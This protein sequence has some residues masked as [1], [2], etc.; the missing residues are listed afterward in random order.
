MWRSILGTVDFSVFV[1]GGTGRFKT[2]LA[3]LLQQHF[4]SGFAAHLLPGTWASTANFNCAQSR[5]VDVAGRYLDQEYACDQALPPTVALPQ[6]TGSG[7]A[8]DGRVAARC[9][10]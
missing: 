8:A 6:S 7:R 5:R 3:A 10:T 1:Y 2:A 4:G 9:P